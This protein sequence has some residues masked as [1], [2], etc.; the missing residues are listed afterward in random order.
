M[1]SSL[2]IKQELFAVHY[3]D[4][5]NATKA[6]RLAGYKGSDNQ[7]AVTG[8]ENI[9]KPKVKERIRELMR[10]KLLPKEEVLLRL[11]GQATGSLSDFIKFDGDKPTLDEVAIK[12]QGHLVRKLN[13]RTKRKIN[14]DRGYEAEED[15]FSLELYSAQKALELLGKYYALFVDRIEHEGS[16]PVKAYGNVSPDDWDDE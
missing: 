5:L 16:I 7:L 14:D 6:A 13:F 3:V 1:G 10:E 4:T 9:R 8:S 2:T 11:E 15:G 12:A